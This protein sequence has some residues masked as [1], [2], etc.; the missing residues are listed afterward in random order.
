MERFDSRSDVT[1]HFPND[2]SQ[3]E[4]KK[5]T[6]P[7]TGDHYLAHAGA[8][9]RFRAAAVAS[10]DPSAVDVLRAKIIA[11]PAVFIK[12]CLCLN[13]NTIFV[14]FQNVPVVSGCLFV[15]ELAFLCFNNDEKPS[16]VCMKVTE[17]QRRIV[18]CFLAAALVHY[19][20]IF[21]NIYTCNTMYS[22]FFLH[23]LSPCAR[24]KPANVNVIYFLHLNT[25]SAGYRL[26]VIQKH[27]F[28]VPA[29]TRQAFWD[30]FFCPSAS[31]ACAVAS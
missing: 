8:R 11:I 31:D 30:F 29:K 14:L 4:K 16:I 28:S 9:N 7:G 24:P 13:L 12:K 21:F 3:I 22:S 6:L 17:H 15:G 27:V 2:Q 25:C 18:H 5:K 10:E 1:L 23:S 19:F 26:P 20:C